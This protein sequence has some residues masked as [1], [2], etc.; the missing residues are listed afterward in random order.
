MFSAVEGYHQYYGG[1]YSVLVRILGAMWRDTISPSVLR[2]V[3]S[4]VG[5]YHQQ[6]RKILFSTV[7]VNP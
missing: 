6:F 3:F 4:T 1:Y 5:G 7:C 2:K